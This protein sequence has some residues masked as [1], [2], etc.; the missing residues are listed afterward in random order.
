MTTALPPPQIV[1][2]ERPGRLQPYVERLQ[3]YGRENAEVVDRAAQERQRLQRLQ[4]N[5]SIIGLVAVFFGFLLAVAFHPI[6][7]LVVLAGI[8]ALIW[9]AQG[10]GKQL[11]ALEESPPADVTGRCALAAWLLTNLQHDLSTRHRLGGRLS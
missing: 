11:R 7:F 1:I 10:P 5:V 2:D 3:A 4:R 8:G 9:A 6:L